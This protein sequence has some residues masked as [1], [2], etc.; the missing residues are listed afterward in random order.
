MRMISRALAAFVSLNIS[1]H[2]SS[3]ILAIENTTSSN[4]SE[5]SH[6]ALKRTL[7]DVNAIIEDRL[8]FKEELLLWMN[9]AS[10]PLDQ[11][12]KD[13]IRLFTSTFKVPNNMVFDHCLKM[14]DSDILLYK[15]AKYIINSDYNDNKKADL[16]YGWFNFLCQNENKAKEY[17]GTCKDETYLCDEYG[18]SETPFAENIISL[19]KKHCNKEALF[20][21]NYY[22]LDC[23]KNTHLF[24]YTNSSH[25]K[26]HVNYSQMFLSKCMDFSDLS[27]ATT[28]LRN[29]AGR[30]G[31]QAAEELNRVAQKI[32]LNMIQHTNSAISDNQLNDFIQ[33]YEIYSK[34]YYHLDLFFVN[35]N[36]EWAQLI[37][38]YNEA[39]ASQGKTPLALGNSSETSTPIAPTINQQTGR[40]LFELC[41]HTIA[42]K[43]LK[44]MEQKVNDL[45]ALYAGLI[46]TAKMSTSGLIMN[47]SPDLSAVN[48]AT[49][50][51]PTKSKRKK[52]KKSAAATTNNVL[53]VTEALGSISINTDSQDVSQLIMQEDSQCTANVSIQEIKN[54]TQDSQEEIRPTIPPHNQAKIE[55]SASKS[56]IKMVQSSQFS[57]TSSSSIE[58]KEIPQWIETLLEAR[59][60][61][62]DEMKKTLCKKLNGR[63][64]QIQN[65]FTI[66]FDGVTGKTFA[67]TSHKPHG[68]QNKKAWPAWRYAMISSLK[69]S[70]HII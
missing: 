66:L 68:A 58:S 54:L 69:R 65:K 21:H 37:S 64:T 3:Q 44:K 34:P 46:N 38:T 8:A 12:S 39:L 17:M 25:F 10:L 13:A 32:N 60:L 49:D 36:M 45:C 61:D 19:L 20:F 63:Y 59:Q 53:S 22:T 50:I 7:N 14:M 2:A 40:T 57:H 16:L 33:K 28:K 52:K 4:L 11:K 56:Q 1:L 30:L 35:K 51:I 15:N 70:G 67:I 23:E 43:V 6:L 41:Q 24:H 47:S 26:K 48:Q 5:A 18:I 31:S 62:F 55:F 9:D 27:D 42:N 29:K